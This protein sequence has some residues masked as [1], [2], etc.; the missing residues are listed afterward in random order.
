MPRRAEFQSAFGEALDEQLAKRNML[1]TDLA[2]AT[3][4]DPSYINRLMTGSKVSPRWA[5]LIADTM[6]LAPAERGKLHAAAA[7][8]WGFKLDLIKDQ[9]KKR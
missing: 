5:D 9:P 6:K 8:T 1:Q 7:R 3:K 4:A 2:R